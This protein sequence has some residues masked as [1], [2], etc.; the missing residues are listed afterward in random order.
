M[1]VAFDFGAAVDLS[2][3]GL[4][5]FHQWLSSVVAFHTRNPIPHRQW[6]VQGPFSCSLLSLFIIVVY[7][8]VFFCLIAND[9]LFTMVWV[10]EKKRCSVS[11]RNAAIHGQNRGHDEAGEALCIPR[12][13][14]HSISGKIVMMNNHLLSPLYHFFLN[15]EGQIVF[16]ARLRMNM[17][18]LL[19]L[20]GPVPSP[21]L[22]GQQPW[23]HL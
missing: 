17:A 3:L 21:M 13:P 1:I 7:S 14:H 8:W 23:L 6:A 12:R 9:G 15:D 2:F 20:M 5:H 4:F 22:T 16:C 18:M 10:N 19:Q 11:D